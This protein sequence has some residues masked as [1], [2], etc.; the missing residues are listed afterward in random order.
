MLMEVTDQFQMIT[1]GA[2]LKEH[3]ALAAH[4]ERT[5]AI[6]NIKAYKESS[7]FFEGPFNNAVASTNNLP[8]NY[9]D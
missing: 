5:R 7:R 4:N 1:E 9:W 2:W 6:P 3:P 8:K